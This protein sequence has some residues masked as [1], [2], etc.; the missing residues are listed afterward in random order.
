[1]LDNEGSMTSPSDVEVKY[2]T[3]SAGEYSYFLTPE[4]LKRSGFRVK[5]EHYR[6]YS[7]C[8]YQSPQV[9]GPYKTRLKPDAR[10]GQTNCFITSPSGESFYGLAICY[11][12][13]NF[14]YELGR[15]AAFKNAALKMLRTFKCLLWAQHHPVNPVTRSSPTAGMYLDI[16]VYPDLAKDIMAFGEQEDEAVT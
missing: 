10:G 9:E 1:M 12:K 4:D 14:C 3:T 5:F 11:A 2:K 7:G 16:N 6:Y 15:Q 8:L 13:D